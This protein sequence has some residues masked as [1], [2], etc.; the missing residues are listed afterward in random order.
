MKGDEAVPSRPWRTIA[1]ELARE[2]NH[3][4]VLELAFELNAAIEQQG[5][6]DLHPP[7]GK[8]GQLLDEKSD[9]LKNGPNPSGAA[10]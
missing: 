4:R 1:Q 5:V 9:R 8:A 2:T 6:S 3:K 7:N 10:Q